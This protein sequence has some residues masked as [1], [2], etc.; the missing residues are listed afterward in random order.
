[1]QHSLVRAGLL[2][3][4]PLRGLASY[5]V[6]LFTYCHTSHNSTTDE[7]II[8]IGIKLQAIISST[9]TFMRSPCTMGTSGNL[10]FQRGCRIR[11][12]WVESEG[13]LINS[14][15][16]GS[17]ENQAVL[18]HLMGEEMLLSS[19]SSSSSVGNSIEERQQLSSWRCQW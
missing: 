19:S 13:L 12:A 17:R 3:S 18:S 2:L 16:T 6:S 15:M 1:M 14:E 10:P 7:P 11:L 4:R 9:P 8:G 5:S